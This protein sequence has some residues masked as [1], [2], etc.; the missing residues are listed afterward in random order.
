MKTARTLDED[1]KELFLKQQKEKYRVKIAKLRKLKKFSSL[2]DMKDSLFK[3]FELVCFAEVRTSGQGWDNKK[4]YKL[5]SDDR[6]IFSHSV[7]YRW[8]GQLSMLELN[9]AKVQD[10]T[11]YLGVPLVFSAN[12]HKSHP[13]ESNHWCKRLVLSP[14][15]QPVR[16]SED[17]LVEVYN[18]GCVSYA[19]WKDTQ[20]LA[21][22]TATFHQ[23]RELIEDVVT[24][25]PH[26]LTTPLPTD[27]NIDCY[28]T[29]RNYRKEFMRCAFSNLYFES[30]G[31]GYKLC[32]IISQDLCE[33]I[34]DPVELLWRTTN[35]KNK[36]P[37]TCVVDVSL[38]HSRSH[39]LLGA[40]SQVTKLVPA[41]PD[42]T[43]YS[44]FSDEVFRLSVSEA[45]LSCDM[46]LVR[47]DEGY[48]LHSL[49]L[50]IT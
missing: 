33:T 13:H 8:W 17:S 6:N 30:D 46:V 23:Y 9:M 47:T 12:K 48:S 35:F 16:V 11:L 20:T 32:G 45:G 28:V 25:A 41:R 37:I 15:S 49:E 5:D 1:F 39:R 10:I 42:V 2:G 7:S 24:Y 44:I 14:S 21:F 18:L 26:T 38:V 43:D 3:H 31:N 34:N 40:V 4:V 22:I 50:R 29:V 27:G 19:L 36:M